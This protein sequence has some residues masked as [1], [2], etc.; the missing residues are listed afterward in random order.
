MLSG[1][2]DLVFKS[3]ENRQI[4]TG[5]CI[6]FVHLGD[7][8]GTMA[9]STYV[10]SLTFLGNKQPRVDEL[11]QKR[12]KHLIVSSILKQR[13]RECHM[14]K[15]RLALRCKIFRFYSA[16]ASSQCHFLA[17]FQNDHALKP[18]IEESLVE[19]SEQL[20]NI[21]LFNEIVDLKRVPDRWLLCLDGPDT[22]LELLRLVLE[23]LLCDR[24]SHYT[25]CNFMLD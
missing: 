9:I 12:L 7:K 11:M 1:L 13:L 17:P 3:V 21:C 22:S 23:L 8:V 10:S 15:R 14:T 16:D 4:Q 2:V 6:D 24:F 19:P 25:S 18:A 5:C 20:V